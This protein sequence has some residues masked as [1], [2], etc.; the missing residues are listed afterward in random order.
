MVFMKLFSG[1]LS[2]F[3][4]PLTPYLEKEG[5]KKRYVMNVAGARFAR[6]SQGYEPRELLLL[7]PA[8]FIISSFSLKSKA[9]I[10]WRKMLY[11][12]Y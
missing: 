6:A 11:L 2:I 7:Y 9:L 12:F 10:Y 4:H 5:E 1:S 8:S 3:N